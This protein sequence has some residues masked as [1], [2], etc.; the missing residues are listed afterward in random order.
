MESQADKV[1]GEN[2][3]VAG[4]VGPGDGGWGGGESY[5]VLWA[6]AVSWASEYGLGLRGKI[7]ILITR[8][9]NYWFTSIT[10]SRMYF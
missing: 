4:E 3:A 1:R 5:T 6:L 7:G 10:F 9:Y 2:K 8:F